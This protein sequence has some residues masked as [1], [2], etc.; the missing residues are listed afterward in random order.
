MLHFGGQTGPVHRAALPPATA[1]L[2]KLLPCCD[3]CHE[4]KEVSRCSGEMS[5][6]A[7]VEH[8]GYVVA[9]H[10]CR[11]SSQVTW[12]ISSRAPVLFCGMSLA[13]CAQERL[14]ACEHGAL[15]QSALLPPWDMLRSQA[16]VGALN[17]PLKSPQTDD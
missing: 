7:D 17:S 11:L 5:R 3:K 1:A 9:Y 13:A 15:A 8:Q 4:G 6:F 12:V 16:A 2:L 14:L 10:C